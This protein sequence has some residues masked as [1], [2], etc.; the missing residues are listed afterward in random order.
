MKC[1][2]H[3]MN[4]FF[5]YKTMGFDARI[6]LDWSSLSVNLVWQGLIECR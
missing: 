6:H 5:V 1:E 2:S 4:S 3:H